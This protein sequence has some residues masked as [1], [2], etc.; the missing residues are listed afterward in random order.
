M[1]KQGQGYSTKEMLRI[2]NNAGMNLLV[3]KK[4]TTLESKIERQKEERDYLQD[5]LT[6]LQ[7]KLS[8]LDPEFKEA[9]KRLNE[10]Q[11]N[12]HSLRAQW[13][14]LQSEIERLED[15]QKKARELKDKT[16]ELSMLL[17]EIYSLQTKQ[18]I[19]KSEKESLL[20]KYQQLIQQKSASLNTLKSTKE[21]IID[22]EKRQERLI[23]EIAGFDIEGYIKGI[24]TKTEELEALFAGGAYDVSVK[25]EID[26]INTVLI[27]MR[28]VD[29]IESVM[30]AASD[31]DLKLIKGLK[32]IKEDNTTKILKDKLD[33]VISGLYSKYSK[34]V[35][36]LNDTKQSQLKE[37]SALKESVDRLQK[38]LSQKEQELKKETDFRDNSKAKIEELS[39]ALNKK[40]Q[41]LED[42]KVQIERLS[43]NIELSK[44]FAEVLE[45]I[46]ENLMK[47]NKKLYSAL[48][49]YK[50]AY[51]KALAAIK[52]KAK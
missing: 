4:K 46:N 36:S 22:L 15:M 29:D 28:A 44:A 35:E 21:Q 23:S 7:M 41:E 26:F 37:L 40:K 17:G 30:G 3:R 9:Q 20:P 24:K 6:G 32:Q 16:T 49:E 5:I 12:Y 11:Q 42:A 48:D 51:E 2:I 39:R 45:P 31:E 25:S 14:S 50:G 27:F 52:S 1:K 34:E 13:E 10:L 38:L 19:A 18:D 43:V 8:E 33:R 47:A